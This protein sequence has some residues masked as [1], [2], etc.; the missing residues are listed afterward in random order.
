[1][2]TFVLPF[3]VCEHLF[4]SNNPPQPQ[5]MAYEHLRWYVPTKTEIQIL[6]SE[7]H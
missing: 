7:F 4:V 6:Q 5:P 3:M 1:M 2:S